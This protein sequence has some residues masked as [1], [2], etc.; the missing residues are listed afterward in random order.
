MSVTDARAVR[1]RTPWA[2]AVAMLVNRV[3]LRAC[4]TA[5]TRTTNRRVAPFGSEAIFQQGVPRCT[6]AWSTET[7]VIPPP[8]WSQTLTAAADWGPSERTT[9][10]NEKA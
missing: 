4:E 3:R 2:V 5:R 6:E 9:I 10:V 8:R 1:R 7:K